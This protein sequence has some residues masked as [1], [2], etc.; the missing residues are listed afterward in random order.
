MISNN[1]LYFITIFGVLWGLPST[2]KGVLLSWGGSFV[3][4]IRKK[5]WYVAPLSFLDS[6]ARAE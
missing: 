5:M 6:E 1:T 2:V 3:G 4:R